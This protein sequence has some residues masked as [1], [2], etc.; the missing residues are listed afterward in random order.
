M[1]SDIIHTRGKITF[2]LPDVTNKHSRQSVWK[3]TAAVLFKDDMCN[4]YAWFIRNRYGLKLSYPLRRAHF[5]VINDR[6]D[7]TLYYKKAKELKNVEIDLSYSI[8]VRTN[9]NYWWLKVFS[10]DAIKIRNEF[11][12]GDP[13]FSFHI[14]IGYPFDIDSEYSHYIHQNIKRYE[15]NILPC[16]SK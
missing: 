10:E 4:Y 14:T 15:K 13:Y 7:S 5:T 6:I 8:D 12:L 16:K 9:G 3:K 2:D 11:G 1:H